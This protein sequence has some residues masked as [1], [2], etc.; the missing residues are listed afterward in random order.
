MDSQGRPSKY[1]P[2]VFKEALYFFVLLRVAGK[3]TLPDEVCRIAITKKILWHECA[4]VIILSI[5]YI[6]VSKRNLLCQ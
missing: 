4:L 5:T 3:K 1:G 6:S 2:I